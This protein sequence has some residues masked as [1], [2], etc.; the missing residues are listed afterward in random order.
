MGSPFVAQAPVGLV[1]VRLTDRRDS[2]AS[3]LNRIPEL[4]QLLFVHRFKGLIKEFGGLMMSRETT[5]A[6]DHSVPPGESRGGR[7]VDNSRDPGEKGRAVITVEQP[8]SDEHPLVDV[9][10]VQVEH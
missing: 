9:K 2:S 4:I 10:L 6:W 7:A 5:Q 8:T 1:A 3:V